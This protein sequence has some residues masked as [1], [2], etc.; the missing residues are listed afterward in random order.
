MKTYNL[1]KKV[2]KIEE[3]LKLNEAKLIT[4]YGNIMEAKSP[5]VKKQYME[6]Y[7]NVF[8]EQVKLTKQYDVY[9]DI[10]KNIDRLINAL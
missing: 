6:I 1:V 7:D 8:S 9:M 10:L 5:D 3:T 4:L 2:I